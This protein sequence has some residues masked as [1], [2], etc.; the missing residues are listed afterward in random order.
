MI[1]KTFI[2]KMNSEEIRKKIVDA[3]IYVC[4]C[5]SFVDADWLVF[6]TRVNNGVHGNGYP[7]E[8]MTKEETRA[9]FLHEVKNPVWRDTVDEFIKLIKEFKDGKTE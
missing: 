2:L 9:L 3:G 6:H 7:F 5:A 4:S 1:D 8:G